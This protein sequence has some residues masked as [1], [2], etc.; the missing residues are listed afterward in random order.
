MT[1][2]DKG[3]RSTFAAGL[4]RRSSAETLA[5][6]SVNSRRSNAHAGAGAAPPPGA[7]KVGGEVGG[8]DGGEDGGE[9]GDEAACAD[10][11]GTGAAASLSKF[12]EPSG[13]SQ[14]TSLTPARDSESECA[15]RRFRS[16]VVPLKINSGT[17]IQSISEFFGLT[18]RSVNATFDTST[19]RSTSSFKENL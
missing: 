1:L 18:A 15:C 11:E 19:F 9:V 5:S 12:N 4:V 7:P 2:M 16:S 8:E 13:S 6:R 10:A 3:A 17:V 14:V